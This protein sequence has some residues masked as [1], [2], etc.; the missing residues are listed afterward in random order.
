[1]ST[2]SDDIPAEGGVPEPF[3]FE[4]GEQVAGQG[5]TGEVVERPG[6][7]SVTVQPAKGPRITL[8]VTRIERIADP[9]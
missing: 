7:Y 8:S 9:S 3:Q 6:P 5:V 1:M 2:K 4:L